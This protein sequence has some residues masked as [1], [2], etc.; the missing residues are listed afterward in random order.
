MAAQGLAHPLLLSS[1]MN[2]DTMNIGGTE[3]QTTYVFFTWCGMIFL[4]LLGLFV[5]SRISL[6]PEKT[7]SLF[8][9]IIGGLENFIVDS[10]AKKD[11]VMFLF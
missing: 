1:V 8:E 9:A 10:L 6:I 3:V 5:K 2:M 7:Q 11:V 4:L